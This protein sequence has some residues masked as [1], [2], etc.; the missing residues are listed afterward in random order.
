MR[1][2]WV[3]IACDF[4]R[5]VVLIG[6]R[7]RAYDVAA[8]GRC[9]VHLICLRCNRPNV[10][11]AKFCVECGAGL[12]RKFCGVCHSVNDAES[13]FCQSCGASLP[14]QPQQAPVCGA[15]SASSF[16]RR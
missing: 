6:R 15:A 9:L 12:L 10:A 14:S 1:R 5:R 16:S 4:A 2:P 7:R 13:H 3:N 11:E 8:G